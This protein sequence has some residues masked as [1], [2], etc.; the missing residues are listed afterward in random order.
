[1]T[2]TPG[3]MAETIMAIGFLVAAIGSA[4]TAILGVLN[5]SSLATVTKQNREHGAAIEVVRNDV[6]SSNAAAIAATKE[7]EQHRRESEV[8]NA[9]LETEL[10]A[11]KAI[12]DAAVADRERSSA[13]AKGYQDRIRELEARLVTPAVSTAVAAPTEVI[14]VNPPESPANVH[15]SH[16]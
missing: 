3:S 9:K 7:N 6:N 2:P 1:V 13:V 12:N 4:L 11:Q 15:E 16:S 8:T 5:H 10:I 14:V